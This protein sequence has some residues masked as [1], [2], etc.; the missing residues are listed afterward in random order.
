MP[1]HAVLFDEWHVRW[2]LP[3]AI[4]PDELQQL[5]TVFRSQEIQQH[6]E[7]LLVTFAQQT[8]PLQSLHV[9]VTL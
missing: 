5:R 4:P 2:W 9:T 6:V 1:E 7:G 3:E 8:P